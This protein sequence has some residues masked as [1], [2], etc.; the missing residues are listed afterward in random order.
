MTSFK[1]FSKIV[2]YLRGEWFKKGINLL[3]QLGTF[4]SVSNEKNHAIIF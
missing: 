1:W 2:Q 3:K 4:L